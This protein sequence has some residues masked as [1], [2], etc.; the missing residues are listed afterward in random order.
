VYVIPPFLLCSQ[1]LQKG[2]SL[3]HKLLRAE[4]AEHIVLTGGLLDGDKT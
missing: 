1:S 2:F 3:L 4:N